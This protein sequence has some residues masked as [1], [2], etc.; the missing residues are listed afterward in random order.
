[1]SA[2]RIMAIGFDM[3]TV[4]VCGYACGCALSRSP[5]LGALFRYMYVHVCGVTF[6]LLVCTLCWAWICDVPLSASMS[7]VSRCVSMH[8]ILCIIT[9]ARVCRTQCLSL[10]SSGISNLSCDA[11]SRRP[12]SGAKNWHVDHTVQ[13][14]YNQHNTASKTARRDFCG[15]T[16]VNRWDEKSS[17]T[18][19]RTPSYRD[20]DEAAL[21]RR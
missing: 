17:D 14:S 8:L 12:Y 20:L 5:S 6:R 16:S 11:F 15:L 10:A 7:R 1:M 9:C 2:N 4:L 18:G 21:E 3:S 13:F 19:N